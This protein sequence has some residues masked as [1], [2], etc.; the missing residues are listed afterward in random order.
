M[1]YLVDMDGN[2]C[3]KEELFG[4]SIK[5][6]A[7]STDSDSGSG[8]FSAIGESL[9]STS[10]SPHYT[11]IHDSFALLTFVTLLLLLL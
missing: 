1:C 10:S 5:S 6:I 8:E 7:D 2:E 9:T 4:T 11:Q 3:N